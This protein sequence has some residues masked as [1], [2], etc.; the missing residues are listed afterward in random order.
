MGTNRQTGERYCQIQS[1]PFMGPPVPVRE[2]LWQK[3]NRV[4]RILKRRYNYVRNLMAEMIGA[5]AVERAEQESL[6]RADALEPGDVVMVLPYERIKATLNRWNQLRGCSFMEEMRPFCG[7]RQRVFK[8]VRQFLD[9]RDYLMKKCSGIVSLENVFCEGTTDFGPCDRG[10]FF[11]WRI[12]WL[13]K[14]VD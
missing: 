12:E 2:A 14:V 13:E 4:K 3:K 5:T 8:K 10:C 9:E 11:F 7:T 6:S 1:F